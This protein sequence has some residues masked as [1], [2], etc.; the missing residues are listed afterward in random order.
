MP[1]DRDTAPTLEWFPICD[2]CLRYHRTV[3]YGTE[4]AVYIPALPTV[5]A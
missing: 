3:A 5:P 2:Q 4:F 1:W